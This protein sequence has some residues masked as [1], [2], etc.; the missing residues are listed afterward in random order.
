MLL[1]LGGFPALDQLIMLRYCCFYRIMLP[2]HEGI[3]V[4]ENMVFRGSLLFARIR[5]TTTQAGTH[6]SYS[7]LS[8]R[9]RSMALFQF[10]LSFLY[11]VLNVLD[12]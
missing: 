8:K 5:S 7:P 4:K 2:I 1:L 3:L 6:K 12:V 10:T 9:N 11:I